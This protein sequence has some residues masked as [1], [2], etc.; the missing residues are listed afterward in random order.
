VQALSSP[1]TSVEKLLSTRDHTILGFVTTSQEP[2]LLGYLKYG[3]KSLFFYHSDAQLVN[4]PSM[5]SILDFF[6]QEEHQRG[7]LG[8]ALFDAFLR[9][10]RQRAEDCA[11]DRPSPKLHSFLARHYGLADLALQQN[12]FAVSAGMLR[13]DNSLNNGERDAS[14]GQGR[15]EQR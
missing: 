6:V 11:Y 1:I 8:K 15:R 2:R 7:G 4:Y 12:R 5:L 13:V 10:T 3:H 14:N 9:L